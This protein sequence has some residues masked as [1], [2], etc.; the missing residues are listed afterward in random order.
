MNQYFFDVKDVARILDIAEPTAYKIMQKLNKELQA[1][2]YKIIH[3]K[4]SI[5]FF[6]ERLMPKC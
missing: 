6:D 4:V 5:K 1:E 2:G 3:G